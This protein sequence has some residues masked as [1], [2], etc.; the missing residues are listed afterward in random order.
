MEDA[1]KITKEID[2]INST[3]LISQ[4]K[5]WLENYNFKKFVDIFSCKNHNDILS[6]FLFLISNLYASQDELKK[7]NFYLSISNFLNPKFIF[8]LSLVVENQII[9]NEYINAKKT[10][11]NFSKEDIFYHWY[12]K[13]IE[14]Q[15]IAEEKNKKQSLNYIEKELLMKLINLMIK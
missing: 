8:N 4:G 13:K 15:I 12:R 11:K 10:L 14:A 5:N 2:Y 6:E 1:K 3:L 7:S 9:N